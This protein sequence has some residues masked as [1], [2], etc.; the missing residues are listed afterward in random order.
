M[1]NGMIA[2]MQS[3]RFVHNRGEHPPIKGYTPFG[4]KTLR[5]A[6]LSF[7]RWIIE[8]ENHTHH[9]ARSIGNCKTDKIL[10]GTR[11]NQG[12]LNA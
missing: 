12:Q 4:S 5:G 10:Y 9:E 2:F 6:L 11:S 1:Q 8:T 7:F 3:S